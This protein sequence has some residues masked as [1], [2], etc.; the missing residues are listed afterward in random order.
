M[1][2]KSLVGWVING[3]ANTLIFYKGKRKPFGDICPPE[4]YGA[5]KV[6]IIIEYL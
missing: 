3:V 6:R 1:K 2:K 5:K 4:H